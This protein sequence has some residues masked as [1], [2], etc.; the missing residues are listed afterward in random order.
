MDKSFHIVETICGNTQY[1]VCVI[2]H[3]QDE[4]APPDYWQM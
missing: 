1:L 4:D 3:P 2:F